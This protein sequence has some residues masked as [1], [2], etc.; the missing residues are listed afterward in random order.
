MAEGLEA[1]CPC[2][3]VLGSPRTDTACVIERCECDDAL[4][5]DD[6]DACEDPFRTRCAGGEER[7][8]GAL[9]GGGQASPNPPLLLHNLFVDSQDLAGHVACWGGGDGGAGNGEL[10]GLAWAAICESG[11]VRH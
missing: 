10:A 11:A 1:V 2:A 5:Y 3:H 4:Y 9:C 6:A 7:L 8:H